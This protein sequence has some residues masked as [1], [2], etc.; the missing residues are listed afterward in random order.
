MQGA[1]LLRGDLA[2][3]TDSQCEIVA[4]RSNG[5]SSGSGSESSSCANQ[6]APLAQ[7]PQ[8]VQARY[9]GSYQLDT[10]SDK[11]Q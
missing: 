7:H 3:I 4:G 6:A 11:L 1:F 9:T 10:I 5:S 8:K 2:F